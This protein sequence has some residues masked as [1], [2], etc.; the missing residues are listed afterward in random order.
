METRSWFGNVANLARRELG[1]LI[2]GMTA[3]LV[4]RTAAA[5]Q[6]CTSVPPSGSDVPI[7]HDI[8]ISDQ[9]GS[10]GRN[11]WEIWGN[12]VYK[13]LDPGDA[14]PSTPP[15][16]TPSDVPH[17]MGQMQDEGIQNF[18]VMDRTD[19]PHGH[20]RRFRI[21]QY[22]DDCDN[23]LVLRG[24]SKQMIIDDTAVIKNLTPN[25]GDTHV[26]P[27]PSFYLEMFE[28]GSNG[29]VQFKKLSQSDLLRLAKCRLG[30]YFINECM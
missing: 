11:N 6:H 12:L 23:D 22:S 24:P 8:W 15:R 2:L 13:W 9:P 21:D 16:Q 20:H 26:Y 28:V 19:L 7:T 1:V 18:N 30:E 27:I 3:T 29:K 17:L 4:A 14:N 5:R 10:D 25:P